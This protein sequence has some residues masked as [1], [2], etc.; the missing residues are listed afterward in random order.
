MSWGS[1]TG[2]HG[3]SDTALTSSLSAKAVENLKWEIPNFNLHFYGPCIWSAELMRGAA[4]QRFSHTIGTC[5]TY[6]Q[7]AL[8]CR[9]I[10]CDYFSTANPPSQ[11]HRALPSHLLPL[12]FLS[13]HIVLCFNTFAAGVSLNTPAKSQINDYSITPLASLLLS[14]YNPFSSNYLSLIQI[15]LFL[16][17]CQTQLNRDG[18]SRQSKKRTK[19]DELKRGNIKNQLAETQMKNEGTNSPKAATLMRIACRSDDIISESRDSWS[20]RH[21]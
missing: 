2:K 9:A 4:E 10:T 15:L 7:V 14:S 21:R 12:R 6:W 18:T 13:F 17:P 5:L 11:N 3:A 20:R 19:K 16:F 1:R 8:M